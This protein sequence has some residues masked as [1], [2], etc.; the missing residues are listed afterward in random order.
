MAM[1]RQNESALDSL[2]RGHLVARSGV[3]PAH[4]NRVEFNPENIDDPLL[5]DLRDAVY[6]H[7]GDIAEPFDLEVDQLSGQIVVGQQATFGYTPKGTFVGPTSVLFWVFTDVEGNGHTPTVGE[8]FTWTFLNAG[9]HTLLVLISDAEGRRTWK[10]VDV[11]IAAS[12]PSSTTTLA[13]YP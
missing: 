9:V 11:A 5:A 10:L 8:T 4:P 2:L 12:I 13:V 6:N 3:D 7:M 1:T